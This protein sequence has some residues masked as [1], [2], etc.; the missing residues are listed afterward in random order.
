M[1]KLTAE[2]TSCFCETRVPF[3][4]LPAVSPIA[5]PTSRRTTP[6]GNNVQAVG[7]HESR[8]NEADPKLHRT[9]HCPFTLPRFAIRFQSGRQCQYRT[10]LDFWGQIQLS[11]KYSATTIEYATDRYLPDA[12]ERNL[13]ASTIYKYRSTSCGFV[14]QSFSRSWCCVD[15]ISP[16]TTGNFRFPSALI[17]V[18][19][20][21]PAPASSF[22]LN[23]PVT[24]PLSEP[25]CL[26]RTASD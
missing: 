17:H 24:R 22:S 4:T 20:G 12:R 19:A 23:C 16:R 10:V 11:H 13:H 25:N 8:E 5:P 6:T 26:K 21:G 14:S 9:P 3:P 1:I 7:V 15:V 2:Y 18:P